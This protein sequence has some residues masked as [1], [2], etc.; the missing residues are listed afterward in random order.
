MQAKLILPQHAP[1]ML[2]EQ[3]NTRAWKHDASGL[4][5]AD[6]PRNLSHLCTWIVHA[7]WSHPHWPVVAV[8]ACN[9]RDV[10]GMPP[11]IINLPG[12]THEV[13]VYAMNPGMPVTVDGDMHFLQPG[14]FVGQF[15]ATS[16]DAARA[17]IEDTVRKIVAGQLNPDTDGFRQWVALFGDAGLRAD[18]RTGE[19]GFYNANVH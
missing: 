18:L 7:P 8:M 9:L 12:A 10:P 16:D 3:T 17:I 5:K 1:D 19:V 15:K 14:N 4:V 6:D 2:N 13:M 11:A